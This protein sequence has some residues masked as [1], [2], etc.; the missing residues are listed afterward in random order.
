MVFGQLGRSLS[1]LIANYIRRLGLVGWLCWIFAFALLPQIIPDVVDGLRFRYETPAKHLQLAL[2]A[3]ATPD[4]D[5]NK[6]CPSPTEAQ[7][8]LD[9]IPASA[10]EHPQAVALLIAIQA[11][12]V[13]DEAEKGNK[14]ENAK[15]SAS[16]QAQKN[17]S[18]E[19]HD[20]FTC[21]N[22]TENTPIMSFDEGSNWWKDDGR[23]WAKLQRKRDE[24]AETSSFIP[25]TLRVD[26]DMDS[27]WLPD[28]ERTCKSY[29]DEKGKVNAVNC[30]GD[31]SKQNHNIPVQFWGG[32]GRNTPS[33]WKCRRERNLLSDN[34]VCRAFN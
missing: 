33:D 22:S 17:I 3:C 10:N 13:R 26:T 11:K 29:P 25:T 9:E 21:A 6:G 15:A 7:R 2:A 28:E 12:R 5:N 8:H 20:A 1:R 31:I 19:A 27:S 32:I 30:S 14:L 24:D 16:I 18:G 34:F 23:C 4:E